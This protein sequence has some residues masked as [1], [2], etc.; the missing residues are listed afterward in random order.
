MF[1]IP[2]NV[3]YLHTDNILPEA[4]AGRFNQTNFDWQCFTSQP[5]YYNL[6]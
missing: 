3:I 6:V 4:Y 5:G 2:N 1:K